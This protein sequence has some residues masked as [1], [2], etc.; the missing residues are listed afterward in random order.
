[1]LFALL[2]CIA[3]IDAF[4]KLLAGQL[5]DSGSEDEYEDEDALAITTEEE[6]EEG[7]DFTPDFTL[8]EGESSLYLYVLD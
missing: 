3:D 7:P 5:S 2:L 8:R 6:H 1:M 4:N